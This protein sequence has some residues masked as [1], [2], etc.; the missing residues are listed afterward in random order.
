MTKRGYIRNSEMSWPFS[1][2]RGEM[3]IFFRFSDQKIY[4]A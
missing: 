4:L 1:S 2:V 3:G